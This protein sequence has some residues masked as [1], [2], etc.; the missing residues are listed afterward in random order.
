MEGTQGRVHPGGGSQRW[1]GRPAGSVERNRGHK[2]P[3]VGGLKEAGGR[4]VA[5]CSGGAGGWG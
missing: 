3:S 1:V 4:R 2:G 5:S